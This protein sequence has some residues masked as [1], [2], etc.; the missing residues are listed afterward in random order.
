MDFFPLLMDDVLD[1]VL[2]A[3]L[4]SPLFTFWVINL[5]IDAFFEEFRS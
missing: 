2:S 3:M 1:F 4:N 5:L